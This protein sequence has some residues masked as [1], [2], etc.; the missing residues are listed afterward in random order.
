MGDR[1]DVVVVGAG[2]AGLVAALA[3]RGALTRDGEVVAPPADAPRVVLCDGQDPPGRKI[4][5]SG[6]GRCN[7]TNAVVT[8]HDMVTS[9]PTLVRNVLRAV[10]VDWT[11]ALFEGLDVPLVEEPLG[12]LFPVSGRARDVL[13]ALVGACRAGRGRE[14]VRTCGRAGGRA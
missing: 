2:A 10:G 8:E 13:E 9:T 5:V 1:A 14:P 7:V 3:A 6:G 4:L 12:K 11:R